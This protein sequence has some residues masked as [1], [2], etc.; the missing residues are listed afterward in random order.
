MSQ[1]AQTG[2]HPR[3]LWV[4]F[5]TE[6][7]ERFGYYL[8]VG[9]LFLYLTN[10]TTGGKGLSRAMGAE[11]LVGDPIR[12]RQ[13]IKPAFK[14]P[15]HKPIFEDLPRS[16]LVLMRDQPLG[17]GNTKKK[18]FR[19]KKIGADGRE[20]RECTGLVRPRFFGF[21]AGKFAHVNPNV[22]AIV[23]DLANHAV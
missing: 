22:T 23:C 12:A 5:L 6:M 3:G 9:I 7:W 2:K 10:T 8:M 20:A 17:K 1:P 14:D 21:L 13:T 16:G 18:S 11:F 15:D 19:K 4:L